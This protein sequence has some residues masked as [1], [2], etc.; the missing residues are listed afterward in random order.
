MIAIS[1]PSSRDGDDHPDIL[2]AI[3]ECYSNRGMKKY[4]YPQSVCLC[5]FMFPLTPWNK[6]SLK[7]E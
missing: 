6:F 1:F 4:S 5:S 7:M 2:T 3:Y